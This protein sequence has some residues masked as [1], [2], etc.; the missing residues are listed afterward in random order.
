MSLKTERVIASI[1]DH[2]NVCHLPL[3]SEGCKE[4]LAIIGD[5]LSSN[6]TSSE[7]ISQYGKLSQA[8]ALIYVYSH[9]RYIVFLDEHAKTIWGSIPTTSPTS[10]TALREGT[11]QPHSKA[12]GALPTEYIGKEPN[13]YLAGE[14]SPARAT[15]GSEDISTFE[16]IPS[17]S[18]PVSKVPGP[19]LPCYILRQHSVLGECYGRNDTLSLIEKSLLPPSATSPPEFTGLRTFALCGLGGVGKTQVAIEFCSRNKSQFDAIFWVYADTEG[20]LAAGFSDISVALGLAEELDVGNKVVNRDR[21]IEWLNRP[22]RRSREEY[23]DNEYS[24]RSD[25]A[26]WLLVFDNADDPELLM[27][28]WPVAGS[29]SILITS[30]DPLAKNH[31]F[32]ISGID[33]EPFPTEVAASFLRIRTGYQ[34]DRD[35]EL[36]RSIAKRLGGHPLALTQVSGVLQRRDLSFDEFLEQYDNPNFL[37]DIHSAQIHHLG[38]GSVRTLSD[39]WA[40][41]KLPPTAV[42]LLDLLSMMD[43]DR[44]PEMIFLNHDSLETIDDFPKNQQVFEAARTTLLR[45]SLVKRDKDERELSVHR[46]IQDNIRMR[47]TPE[48]FTVA[49]HMALDLVTDSWPK[50][51]VLFCQEIVRWTQCSKLLPHIDRLKLLYSQ[52]TF[53]PRTLDKKL[54]FADLA[55]QVGWSV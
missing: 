37:A 50:G 18:G 54:Q 8:L 3:S 6:H 9:I 19:K 42:C 47:M 52:S 41:E 46:L 31:I 22:H 1:A 7:N 21:V 34:R 14:A 28:Y 27:D 13:R 25:D 36:S 53:L 24:A 16:I 10:P 2:R 44:I 4:L 45:N 20:K 49:F 39:L 48:R 32:G 35:T 33:L 51:D 43:A 12:Y 17:K 38:G 55:T 15:A 5:I 11:D 30:R 40:F 29:G 26:K 23:D